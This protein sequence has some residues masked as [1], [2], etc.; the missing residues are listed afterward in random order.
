MSPERQQVYWYPGIYLQPQHFQAVDLY[1]NYMFSRQRQHTMPWNVGIMHCDFNLEVLVN[2]TLK[3]DR[4]QAILPSGD[5]LEY[6]GN[7]VLVPRQFREIWTQREKPLT[8]WLAL[9]RFDPNQVNVSESLPHRWVPSKDFGTMKDVYFNGPECCV[10]RIL[11]N[12]QILSDDEKQSAVDCEFLPLVR[13]CYENDRVI[14][15]PHFCPPVVA[16]RSYPTLKQ[17]SDGLY[18]ELSNRAY[19]IAEYKRK[20]PQLNVTQEYMS[21]LLLLHSLNRALPLLQHY[22]NTP[23]LHPWL[24]YGALM[25]LAGE[26]SSFTE[27]C[28]LS[29]KREDIILLQP[30]DHFNLYSCFASVRKAIMVLL[31]SLSLEKSTWVALH[32]DKHRIFSGELQTLPWQ[33]VKTILLMLRAEIIADI[34]FNEIA[35]FKVASR[36]EIQTLIQH[37]L[38]GIS[39]TKLNPPPPGVPYRK[40]MV[41]F[42]L[43]QQDNL[44]ESVEKN[45]KIAFYWDNAPSDLQVQIIFMGGES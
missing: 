23:N 11:Y 39:A 21:K 24:L 29:D 44:W 17:L 14:L 10:S 4:L 15:D 12:A 6:P 18:A 31:N 22:G 37:A 32:E 3:I 9:R 42:Q 5:Y 38:P 36:S 2:F 34:D 28:R 27:P 7:S 26:L 40:D 41:Y 13:L 8:L 19:Q 30:Y 33:N 25:Q 35:C 16:M 1:S 45:Q 43:S 20:E